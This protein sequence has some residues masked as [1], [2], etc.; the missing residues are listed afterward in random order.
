MGP[1][2]V[3]LAGVIGLVLGWFGWDCLV[4]GGLAAFVLAG[5]YGV[6]GIGLG[7]AGRRTALAFGPWMLAGAWVGLVAGPAIAGLYLDLGGLA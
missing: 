5:V 3:K 7:R 4:V 6:I 2:D 1:G